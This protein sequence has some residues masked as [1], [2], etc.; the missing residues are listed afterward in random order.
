MNEEKPPRAEAE[1]FVLTTSL[2]FTF[3]LRHCF[4]EKGI[5]LLPANS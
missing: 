2:I 1:K 4:L 5:F 3:A